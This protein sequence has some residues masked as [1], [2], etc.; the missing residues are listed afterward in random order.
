MTEIEVKI[1][2]ISPLDIQAKLKEIG[3]IKHFD[4]EMHAAFFDF[5]DGRIRAKGDVLRLRKEGEK[6][7]LAYKKRISKDGAK[8]MEEHETTISDFEVLREILSHLGIHSLTETRKFRTEYVLGDTHIVIDDY[9]D[10]LGY[11][12][13]FIEVEAPSLARLY[14]VVQLLGFQES[15]CKSWDTRDLVRYYSSNTQGPSIR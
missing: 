7:V 1:L 3:A 8:I 5:E 9:Q 11:I 14:E 12:P 13:S 15:D 4:G 2:E 10:A 6:I